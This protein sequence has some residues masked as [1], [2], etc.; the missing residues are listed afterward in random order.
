MLFVPES[1][2]AIVPIKKPL[3][4]KFLCR[5]NSLNFPG[6]LKTEQNKRRRYLVAFHGQ[7]PPLSG[8]FRAIGNIVCAC[9]PTYMLNAV[10]KWSM[11]GVL[12]VRVLWLILCFKYYN[13]I[14]GRKGSRPTS[15]GTQVILA[16]LAAL[17]ERI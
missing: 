9:L 7:L 1:S 5:I 8:M 3:M 12:L 16:H 10:G 13:L 14:R 6:D 4:L 2:F 17:R 11:N 15:Y